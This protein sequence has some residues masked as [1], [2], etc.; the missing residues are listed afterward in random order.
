MS[1]VAALRELKEES[2]VAAGEWSHPD[3]PPILR[4]QTKR[5][6]SLYSITGEKTAS[7]R[8][9]NFNHCIDEIG[10]WAKMDISSESPY[11]VLKKMFS[12]SQIRKM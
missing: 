8:E 4:R 2:G 5:S 6:R 12:P 7:S 1:R 9:S 3:L 10:V 11:T